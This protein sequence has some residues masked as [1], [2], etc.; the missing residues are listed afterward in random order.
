MKKTIILAAVAS[1]LS[2]VS[3]AAEAPKVKIGGRMDVMAGSVKESNGYRTTNPSNPSNA[4]ALQKS[5]IV[6][7]TKIDVNVDGKINENV[8]YGGFIR[9]HADSSAATNK[10]SSIGDKTMV[11]IQHDKIGKLEGG[12]MPGAGGLFEMD[13]VFLNKGTWGI[14]GFWSQWV[15]DKTKRTSAAIPVPLNTRSAEF[16]VSPNLPS[17]YSGNHY[18]DAPKVNFFTKPIKTITLGVSFIPDMD[19]TGSIAGIAPKNSGPVDSDRYFGAAAGSYPATF[20]NIW[21]G[22]VM[23]EQKFGDYGV[24]ASLVGE[25]GKAKLDAL[26]NLK[27]AEAGIN[28]SYKEFHL[29][30]SYGDWFKSLTL[31]NPVAGA[32]QGGKYYTVGFG[33]EINKVGYSV[34][35]ISSKKAGGIEALRTKAALNA[36]PTSV[37]SDFDYNRLKATSFDVEY[38]LAPGFKPYAG[39]TF[40]KFK[41]SKGHKDSGQVIMAGTRLLF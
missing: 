27:A 21:S 15:Q 39:V 33:H 37:L 23:Y 32:K 5:A 40:F 36:L 12:N 38:H 31:K 16:L 17:N 29:V 20:R 22:G 8:K 11:Y 28:L 18:S 26:R 24:K 3:I 6:N 10:E 13:T 34:T 2:I 14:E 1:S 25:V 4:N 30:G 35:H 41:E 7:D 19:N 9:L